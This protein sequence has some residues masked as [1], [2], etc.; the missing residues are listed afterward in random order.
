V[1]KKRKK[2]GK[3]DNGRTMDGGKREA[4]DKNKRLHKRE[5]DYREKRKTTVKGTSGRTQYAKG[6][7]LKKRQVRTSS[8]RPE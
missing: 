3:P 4:N 8:R 2:G 7:V 1:G 6:K 5:D